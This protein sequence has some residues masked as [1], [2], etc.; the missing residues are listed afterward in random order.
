MKEYQ[1]IE[2]GITIGRFNTAES[3][4]DTFEEYIVK[5]NRYA[6]KKEVEI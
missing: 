3:R 6:M 5:T 1:I 2:G 4:D